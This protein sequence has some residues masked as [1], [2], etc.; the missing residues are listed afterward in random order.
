MAFTQQILL[1]R[2][3]R[4]DALY[5]GIVRL[6]IQERAGRDVDLEAMQFNLQDFENASLDDHRSWKEANAQRS[7]QA[8]MGGCLCWLLFRF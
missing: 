2:L 5:G 8:L 4:D 7:Q 3:S 1:G 6:D